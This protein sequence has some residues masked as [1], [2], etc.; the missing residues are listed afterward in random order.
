[1]DAFA[2]PTNR[3]C[4]AFWSQAEDAFAHALDYPHAGA[5]WANPPF[6]RLDEVMMKASRKGWLMLVVAP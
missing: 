6:S 1:M 3:R 2:T 5:L 4:P